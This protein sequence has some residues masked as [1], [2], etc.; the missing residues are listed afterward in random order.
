MIENKKI[1]A[2]SAVLAY[3]KEEEDAVSALAMQRERAQRIS[4]CRMPSPMSIWGVTGRQAQM[5]FRNLMQ[6]KA[7]HG[8]RR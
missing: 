5:Q 4:S 8:L 7:F 2:V 3:I 6:A 1:A